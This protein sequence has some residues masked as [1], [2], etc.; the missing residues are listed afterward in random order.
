M[1]QRCSAEYSSMKRVCLMQNKKNRFF[2]VVFILGLATSAYGQKWLGKTELVLNLSPTYDNNL[3]KYSQKYLDRFENREDEGR[4]HIDTFDDLLLSGYAEIRQSLKPFGQHSFEL[5]F[6]MTGKAHYQN[7]VKNWQKFNLNVSR[8]LTSDLK[9]KLDY[10]YLPEFYVRHYR[11][12]AAIDLTGFSPESFKPFVFDKENYTF[13]L[14]YKLSKNLELDLELDY[15]KYFHNEYFTEYDSDN[16]LYAVGL[17]YKH[18]RNG[19]ISGS[20]SYSFSNADGED[21]YLAQRE[22]AELANASYTEELYWLRYDYSLPKILGYKTSI[23]A[24]V[25][26]FV[27]YYTTEQFVE[28][29]PLHAGRVDDNFRVYLNYN[30]RYSRALRLRLFAQFIMRDSHSSSPYNNGFLSDEKDYKQYI[31]GVAV[32]YNLSW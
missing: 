15:F 3:L 8:K 18:N 29:D 7:P 26:Y 10:G 13:T 32:T 28:L 27:R 5:R 16:W 9:V 14:S 11:A 31:S 2:A 17:A 25:R 24:T 22:N 20:Y 23:N 30:I 21:I 12:Q 19:T 1:A 4:F 6:R